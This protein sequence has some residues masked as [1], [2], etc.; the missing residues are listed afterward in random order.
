MAA[1]QSWMPKWPFHTMPSKNGYTS[2]TSRKVA[3]DCGCRRAR[4]AMPPETM[5]GMAAAKVSRKKN[6]TSS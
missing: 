3:A 6:F 4:S 2:P 5:A 1:S